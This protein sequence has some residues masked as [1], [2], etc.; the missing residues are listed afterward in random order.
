MRAV[1]TVETTT[2]SQPAITRS[3][4]NSGTLLLITHPP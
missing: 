3:S 1:V 2:A 4:A